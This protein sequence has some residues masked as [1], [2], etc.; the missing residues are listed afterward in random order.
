MGV[1]FSLGNVALGVVFLAQPLGKDVTHVLRR[2]SNGEGVVG[3]VLGHGGDGD[4]LGVGE[5]GARGAVVVTQQ[6][7]DLANTIRTVIE[8]EDGCRRL[9]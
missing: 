6:L 9:G 1:L 7:G 8:E 4:V 2:E 3:L 5:V